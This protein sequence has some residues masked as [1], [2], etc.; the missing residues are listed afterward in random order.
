MSKT[1]FSV[2]AIALFFLVIMSSCFLLSLG[3]G[4]TMPNDGSGLDVEADSFTSNSG[5][6]A[7]KADATSA[8]KVGKN[9]KSGRNK[10]R[11]SGMQL[12]SEVIDIASMFGGDAVE[13]A[14]E[15]F[16]TNI[17]QTTSLLKSLANENTIDSVNFLIRS[18][19][20]S[21]GDAARQVASE[22]T[23]SSTMAPSDFSEFLDAF[24]AT[25]L[26]KCRAKS[27]F[28]LGILPQ[29]E[30]ILP[31]LLQ[32]LAELYENFHTS[33]NGFGLTFSLLKQATM[34]LT[35]FERP[36]YVGKDTFK[37][38]VDFPTEIQSQ[39]EHVLDELISS[40]DI[41][42]SQIDMVLGMIRMAAQ[43]FSSSRRYDKEEL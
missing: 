37:T 42:Q 39:F 10:Y 15:D 2:K 13:Q 24:R 31:S 30:A 28:A 17:H 33:T 5:A 7:S 9:A 6:F 18:A 14:V 36:E 35:I 3:K 4:T 38:F 26:Q 27:N 12:L 20:S 19:I 22:N 41:D 43:N 8:S 1:I 11:K 32:G 40:Y 16:K 25:L 21:L 34:V 29:I 23:E